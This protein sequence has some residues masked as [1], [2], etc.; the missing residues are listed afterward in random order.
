MQQVD[1]KP[2]VEL[3]ENGNALAPTTTEKYDLALICMEEL[4]P[5]YC[6][7][8]HHHGIGIVEKLYSMTRLALYGHPGVCR[9]SDADRHSIYDGK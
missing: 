5:N 6:P 3:F 7:G 9:N 1:D 4:A 2:T 8:I